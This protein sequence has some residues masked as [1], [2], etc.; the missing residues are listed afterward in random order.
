MYRQALNIYIQGLSIQ[1][2]HY[3]GRSG[4]LPDRAGYK[5]G[6]DPAA[7]H[8]NVRGRG[9]RGWPYQMY[10][11][12]VNVYTPHPPPQR[13]HPERGHV[14]DYN[15]RVLQSGTTTGVNNQVLQ[16]TFYS[17]QRIAHSPQ[18]TQRAKGPILIEFYLLSRPAV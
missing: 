10:T 16:R 15:R 4:S 11:P 13:L 17:T 1:I 3:I 5:R 9:A 8:Q 2:Y 18:R 12:P 7:R 14:G 6:S